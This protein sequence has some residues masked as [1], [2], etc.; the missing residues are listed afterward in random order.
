MLS[1]IIQVPAHTAH[2]AP[3][4][5]G[6][7]L[8]ILEVYLPKIM[9]VSRLITRTTKWINAIR[10]KSSFM[11]V[12]WICRWWRSSCLFDP[13]PSFWVSFSADSLMALFCSWLRR[14]SSYKGNV[15][16]K[17]K[18]ILQVCG[19]VPHNNNNNKAVGTFSWWPCS[20]STNCCWC[21]MSMVDM[22]VLSSASIFLRS[23]TFPFSCL[24]SLSSLVAAVLADTS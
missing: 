10:E 17:K 23:S 9:F 1:C 4:E 8:S 18:I 19:K 6:S 11:R 2:S 22:T 21:S 15:N 5:S 7:V 16:I 12:T 24:T 20:S 13:S 14:Y 3:A